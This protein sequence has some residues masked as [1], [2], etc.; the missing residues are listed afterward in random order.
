MKLI[1]G[2]SVS[3]PDA[4]NAVTLSGALPLIFYHHLSAARAPLCSS[5]PISLNARTLRLF[6]RLW[7]GFELANR[8]S[9]QTALTQKYRAVYQKLLTDDL[10]SPSMVDLCRCVFDDHQRFYPPAT[11]LAGSRIP[12]RMTI[13]P[14]SYRHSGSLKLTYT[15]G[16]SAIA[17]F[18][19]SKRPEHANTR[20]VVMRT[21]E[22]LDLV[23]LR[24]N[25]H[26]LQNRGRVTYEWVT[27]GPKIRLWHYPLDRKGD[28][29]FALRVLLDADTER[30]S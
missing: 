18:E 3:I 21:V 7:H 2:S 9:L 13:N 26:R 11:L 15:F 4:T 14:F 8:H 19:L 22:I 27:D 17:R 28:H 1:L 20:T 16:G 5:I 29:M 23:T 24:T 10:V 12:Q 30:P 6:L 25:P